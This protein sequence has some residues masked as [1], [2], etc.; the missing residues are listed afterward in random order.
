MKANE[1]RLSSTHHSE[2][3]GTEVGDTA[4]QDVVSGASLALSVALPPSSAL[5][6][7]LTRGR[8][9]ALVALLGPAFVASIAYVDPGNFATSVQGGAQFGFELLWV[10]VAAKLM[11]MLVQY[12]A[13]KLGIVTGRTFAEL[14]GE[15]FPRPVARSLWLQAEVMAMATDLAEFTGAALGLNLLFGVP[16]V[17]VALLTAPIAFAI[18]QLQTRGF[19]HFDLAITAALGIIFAGFLYEVVR[20]DPDPQQT[21]GGLVPH[22]SGGAEAVLAAGIIGAT[23]MP[24]VIYLHS[25]LTS[26]RIPCRNDQERSLVLRFERL[27]V[28]VALGIAGL[29]NVSMLAIAAQLFHNG[30]YAGVSSIQQGHADLITRVGGGAAIAFAV[31][32]FASGAASSSVGTYAGQVV[33]QGLIGKQ[34]RYLFVAE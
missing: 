32:L 33:M 29:V 5:D 7:I 17:V 18:L 16:I 30:A 4:D 15:R 8:L 23:V 13:A 3:S 12:L 19:R 6:V 2:Q 24:H 1:H 34:V 11:A 21:L 26:R 9:S 10:V 20:I 31:A 14:C 27:D 25:A 22:L 28:V